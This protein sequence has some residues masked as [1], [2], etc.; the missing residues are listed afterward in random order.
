[1][2]TKTTV[3]ASA[4]VNPL[5]NLSAKKSGIIQYAVITSALDIGYNEYRQMDYKQGATREINRAHTVGVRTNSAVKF[6]ALSGTD[7]TNPLDDYNDQSTT[8]DYKG[9]VEEKLDFMPM[10][11]IKSD[12]FPDGV[13]EASDASPTKQ[14][15]LQVAKAMNID[16][17]KITDSILK[18]K[19]VP[20]QGSAEWNKYGK[21]YRSSGEDKKESESAYRNDLVKKSEEKAKGMDDVTDISVG[22]YGTFN[23]KA[24]V[25]PEAMYHTL[26]SCLE[27]TTPYKPV[28][29][30][31]PGTPGTGN[32]GDPG[33]VPPT[34]GTPDTNLG[35]ARR[36]GIHGK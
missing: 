15:A 2:A 13:I 11:M 33:Y 29:A 4:S 30:G 9:T 26:L 22:Y 5:A 6:V 24:R 36:F 27:K 3:S 21:A 34:P 14:A 25:M 18:D 19:K 17:E 16:L 35:T 23:E 12:E 31:I 1:M 28:I 32:P 10:C 7:V 20:A 8:R